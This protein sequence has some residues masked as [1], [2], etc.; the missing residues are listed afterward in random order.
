MNDFAIC[1]FF[2]FCSRSALSCYKGKAGIDF[3]INMLNRKT[4][5]AIKCVLGILL[6]IIGTVHSCGFVGVRVILHQVGIFFVSR[7]TSRMPPCLAYAFPHPPFTVR[8][9]QS[10]LKCQINNAIYNLARFVTNN[11]RHDLFVQSKQ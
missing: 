8:V 1:T 3:R 6:E 7:L 4:C 9:F 5:L 2:S 11:S 10:L